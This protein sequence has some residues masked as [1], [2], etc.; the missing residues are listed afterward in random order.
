[1]R[2]RLR[3]T[4]AASAVLAA[5]PTAVAGAAPAGRELA[6][7]PARMLV[8]AQE[9]SLWPSRGTVPGG[10]VEV[11]LWNRGQDPHDLRVKRLGGT[12][13]GSAASARGIAP[14]AS[15]GRAEAF[16]RLPA[17]RYELYCALPQHARRGM[18]AV[19]VVR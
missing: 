6:S 17:G 1:M 18:H 9:W 3:S 13:R 11:T 8:Y 7:A 10:T 5:V 16:W 15:G 4:L 12:R 14:L 19:I 2:R